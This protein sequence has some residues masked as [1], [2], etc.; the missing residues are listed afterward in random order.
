MLKDFDVKI[1]KMNVGGVGAQLKVQ[2][3]I[4]YKKQEQ[5]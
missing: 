4:E 2:Y 5:R 1:R 3:Y